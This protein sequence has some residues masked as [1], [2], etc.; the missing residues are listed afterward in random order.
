[1]IMA[2]PRVRGECFVCVCVCEGGGG[3]VG[4]ERDSGVYC[5]ASCVAQL[6]SDR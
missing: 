2:T 5:P 3:G 6:C 4:R 1:M